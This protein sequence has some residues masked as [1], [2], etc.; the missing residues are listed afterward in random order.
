MTYENS[1]FQEY[2]ELCDIKNNNEIA[3]RYKYFYFF[4]EYSCSTFR[5]IDKI[6]VTIQKLLRINRNKNITFY[7]GS[8]WFSI[9][10]EFAKYVISREKDI[11]KVFRYTLCCD[12]V[13][14]SHSLE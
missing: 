1:N 14:V 4:Q 7:K 8:N 5:V 12:E 13:S 2:L 6:C 9:T 10:N 3:K 11:R